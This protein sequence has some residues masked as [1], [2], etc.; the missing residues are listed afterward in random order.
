[1]IT[2]KILWAAIIISMIIGGIAG[3]AIDRFESQ[4]SSS[5][6]GKTKFIN[7]MTNE[8]DLTVV[9]QKQLDSIV[10]YVH[11]KFQAIRK[12]FR[13]EL[14]NQIDSTQDMIKSILTPV[15]RSKIDALYSKTKTGSDNK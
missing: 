1:M 6:F 14:E 4:P 12:N 8:L 2:K 9:Q 11:P 7:Y 10:T 5:H 13:S 3:F 15:Q